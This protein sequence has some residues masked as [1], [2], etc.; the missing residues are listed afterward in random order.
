MKPISHIIISPRIT[1]KAGVMTEAKKVYTFEVALDANKKDVAFAIKALYKVEPIKVNI[2]RLPR[3]DIMVRGKKGQG[4]L[5]KKAIV[6]LKEG[7]SIT[8]S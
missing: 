3:K 1:E 4:P 2:I 6:F 8:I 7:D 5:I